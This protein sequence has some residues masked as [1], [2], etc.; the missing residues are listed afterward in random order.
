[1]LRFK[2]IIWQLLHFLKVYT[3]PKI[4]FLEFQNQFKIENLYS[5]SKL[6]AKLQ[7]QKIENPPQEVIQLCFD[8]KNK[9]ANSIIKL[10]IL[11]VCPLPEVSPGAFSLYSNLCEAL[12]FIGIETKLVLV[13][14][15]IQ[16]KITDF[17]P[18][19]L[20]SDDFKSIFNA[21]N[22]DFINQY[23]TKNKLIWGIT[24]YIEAYGYNTPLAKRVEEAKN[25]G[26]NFYY[27]FRSQSYCKSRKE[28][29]PIFENNFDLISVEFGANPLKYYPV[30][31]KK[32][33]DFIFIGSTN[34]DK[35]ARYIQ[36]FK[37]IFSQFP[38]G[39]LYGP[40]WQFCKDFKFDQDLELKAYSASKIGINLHIENQI[41][42]AS[43]LNERT[44]QLALCK[45]PQLIDNPKILNDIFPNDCFFVAK[46]EM[47]YKDLLEYMLQNPFECKMKAQNA[48][49]HTLKYHTN[50]HRAEKFV[51]D[52][53]KYF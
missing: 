12:R 34:R 11:I 7:N 53:K 46:N 40:G 27:T 28:Y 10:R 32:L 26:I 3:H 42:W 39:V 38:N 5:Y 30:E 14:Q 44:Y 47:E 22:I 41:E 20:L 50:F 24:A 16:N 19:I 4:A 43:E 18:N 9:Y 17:K 36:F 49:L 2:S 35:W 8:F 45:I 15:N 29:A 23:R 37:V 31:S 33:F 51:L 21:I 48:Y 13:N 25:N 52:L 1:M 6:K